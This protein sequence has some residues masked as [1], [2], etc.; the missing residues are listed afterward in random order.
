MKTDNDR[1][2]DP[3]FIKGPIAPQADREERKRQVEE[4]ARRLAELFLPENLAPGR[5]AAQVQ[6]ENDRRLRLLED[7]I[8]SFTKAREDFAQAAKMPVAALWQILR[9]ANDA[10]HVNG[11]GS[12]WSESNG[13][14]WERVRALAD[15]AL[16][17][18]LRVITDAGDRAAVQHAIDASASP[19]PGGA[20][21]ASSGGP[22]S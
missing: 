9:I 7:A 13:P 5:S 3:G 15:W 21:A 22:Q 14:F 2:P 16:S 18:E 10:I 17:G 12:G 1:D 6:A 19:K 20:S 4:R 11:D 8:S